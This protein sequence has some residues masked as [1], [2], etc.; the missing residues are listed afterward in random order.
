MKQTAA[1]I[2]RDAAASIDIFLPAEL[3]T[4]TNGEEVHKIEAH[5]RDYSLMLSNNLFKGENERIDLSV[6]I[7]KQ[8]QAVITIN[9]QQCRLPAQLR[10]KAPYYP[11]WFN[12]ANHCC[13]GIFQN[14]MLFLTP[15]KIEEI[16]ARNKGSFAKLNYNG[17]REILGYLAKYCHSFSFVYSAEFTGHI[18][19]IDPGDWFEKMVGTSEAISLRIGLAKGLLDN[20]HPADRE[21]SEVLF[22]S[23]NEK[24]FYEA[25]IYCP[26]P[27]L[28]ENPELE[29]GQFQIWINDLPLPVG[30]T[31]GTNFFLSEGGGS[32]TGQNMFNPGKRNHP[33]F[34]T[35]F[36]YRDIKELPEVIRE[37]GIVFGTFGT[38]ILHL[39]SM[40][41]E[42]AGVWMNHFVVQQIFS[43]VQYYP[44][45]KELFAKKFDLLFLT[46]VVRQLASEGIPVRN[47]KRIIEG[48]LAAGDTLIANGSAIEFLP[49]LSVSIT[50]DDTPITPETDWKRMA[51]LVRKVLREELSILLTTNHAIN[52][53]LVNW[54]METALI[55]MSELSTD[56][57]KEFEK[58]LPVKLGNLENSTQL[59]CIL[60]TDLCRPII[61]KLVAVEYPF[62]KVLSYLE[63]SPSMN[64]T[65]IGRV[66]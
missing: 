26:L 55:K 8:P 41:R 30:Y 58:R 63:L 28:F 39:A 60:S 66:G 38:M 20:K 27:E 21:T 17:R 64:I 32:I 16:S 34:N 15:G 57:I 47:L 52:V 42:N 7:S 29:A 14:R 22:T 50:K 40:I 1:T 51:N 25:G 5:V 13:E 3:F 54:E 36:T 59:H 18:S 24:L 10:Q 44:F 49:E 56:A 33:N 4:G 31:I 35:G 12:I 37:K 61:Q 2:A 45:S 48:C 65:T 6:V 46:K 9:G 43:K 53:L 11:D 19:T 62:L 23:M